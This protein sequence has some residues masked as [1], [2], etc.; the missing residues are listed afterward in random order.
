VAVDGSSVL[1]RFTHEYLQFDPKLQPK[2][3]EIEGMLTTMHGNEMTE[4]IDLCN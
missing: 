3:Y 1:P 4:V 2:K